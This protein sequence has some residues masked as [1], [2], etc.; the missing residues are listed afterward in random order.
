MEI[1][2]DICLAIGLVVCFLGF[3]AKLKSDME[4]NSIIH[5]IDAADFNEVQ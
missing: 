3:V 5:H 1:N 4:Y 2:A